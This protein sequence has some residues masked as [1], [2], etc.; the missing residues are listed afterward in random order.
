MEAS[1]SKVIKV[2]KF[3]LDQ[4]LRLLNLKLEA[5]SNK[6]LKGEVSLDFSLVHSKEGRN[7]SLILKDHKGLGH[8]SIPAKVIKSLLT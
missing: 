6:K 1:H 4:D 7:S 3:N 8:S 2:Q 5:N